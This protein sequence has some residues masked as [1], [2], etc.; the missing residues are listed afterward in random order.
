MKPSDPKHRRASSSFL[1]QMLP[2]AWVGRSLQGMSPVERRQLVELQV[3]VTRPIIGGVVFSGAV[4]LMMAGLFEWSGLAPGIGYPWWMTLLA[5]LG[6]GVCAFAIGQA[7]DWRMQLALSLVGTLLVGVFLSLPTPGETGQLAIRNSLF[8]LLPIALLALLARRPG[9]LCVIAVMVGLAAA[10]VLMHGAPATG[11][12]LY[13]LYTATTICF[14][15]MLKGY[16]MDFAI[17]AF[18]MRNRLR[19]QAVTDG[20]TGLIN[21][22]GWNR[23]AAATYMSAHESARA[24][25]FAFFDIDHF[26]VVNDTHGHDA[27]DQVLQALGRILRARTDREC[28]SARLGGE[29]FVVLFAGRTP[30]QVEELVREVRGEFEREVA[31]FK[32]TVSAGVAHR[33]PA[34]PMDQH[35]RRTDIALYEAKRAGRDRLVVSDLPAPATA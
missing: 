16:R 24:L 33:Q 13:W 10:R 7:E 27:G 17:A 25:S 2:R 21:R 18:Q 35:L 32:V 11:S 23:E 19:L 5:A 31:A 8:Q 1:V 12:A 20:L 28:I 15:L 3:V 26:K 30:V 6:T 4:I 34:E 22:E 29:E 14:G 9:A